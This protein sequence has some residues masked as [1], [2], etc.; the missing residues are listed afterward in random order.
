MGLTEKFVRRT[1]TYTDHAGAKISF[2]IHLEKLDSGYLVVAEETPESRGSRLG[3]ALSSFSPK[4]PDLALVK[5]RD[6]IRREINVRYL[7]EDD[8][9]LRLTQEATRL[10]ISQRER[11]EGSTETIF[12]VNGRAI[13]SEQFFALLKDYE[14]WEAEFHIR[15]P[16]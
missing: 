14:G 5:L 16:D 8:G 4:A 13:D 9:Q 2:N 15:Y 7:C 11:G 12:E 1:E 3:Y 6:K 10:R